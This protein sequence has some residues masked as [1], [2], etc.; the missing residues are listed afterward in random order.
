MMVITIGTIIGDIM[1]EDT[2]SS[3]Q[4]TGEVTWQTLS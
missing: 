2:S 3:S 4:Q 1:G